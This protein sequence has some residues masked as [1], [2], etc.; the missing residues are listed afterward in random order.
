MEKNTL[1]SALKEFSQTSGTNANDVKEFFALM[2][3]G[4]IKRMPKEDMATVL[5]G[6][7][8]V[9]TQ[10]KDGLLE[11]GKFGGVN[12]TY[13]TI[14]IETKG[15][16]QVTASLILS[17]SALTS[18]RPS[19]YYIAIYRSTGVTPPKVEVKLL[20]GTYSI[21]I[22]TKTDSDGS[23]R[24]YAKRVNYT[25]V[26]SATMYCNIGTSNLLM[27]KVNDESELEGSTEATLVE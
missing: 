15:N 21:Q 13:S 6:L 12:D 4:S 22:V 19:L 7:I 1:E 17:I 2:S 18:G 10:T 23:F 16:K 9:A 20:S 8:G 27:S 24:I 25:P 3:D 26:L 5:G 14:L 11:A